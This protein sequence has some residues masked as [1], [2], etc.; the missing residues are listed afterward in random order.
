MIRRWSA[1]AAAALAG[2]LVAAITTL[3]LALLIFVATLAIRAPAFMDWLFGLAL[4]AVAGLTFALV[5][6]D[7]RRNLTGSRAL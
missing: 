5:F 4:L 7:V 2:V 1:I 6:R 3:S